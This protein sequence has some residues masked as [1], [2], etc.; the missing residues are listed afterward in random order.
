MLAELIQ[1]VNYD[2]GASEQIVWEVDTRRQPYTWRQDLKKVFWRRCRRRQGFES[3]RLSPCGK[4]LSIVH[5]DGAYLVR[6]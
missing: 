4:Y 1:R 3:Q 6:L 5:A 2:L